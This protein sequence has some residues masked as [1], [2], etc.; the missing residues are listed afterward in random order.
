M[1]WTLFLQKTCGHK[2]T[3][4]LLQQHSFVLVCRLFHFHGLP[5]SDDLSSYFL[6][7][8]LFTGGAHL[9]LVHISFNGVALACSFG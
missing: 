6:N 5:G 8:V 4:Q 7:I 9:T 1:H 2:Q 3:F